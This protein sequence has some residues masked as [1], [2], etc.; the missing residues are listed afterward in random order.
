MEISL[1]AKWVLL[2]VFLILVLIIIA[3]LN[4]KGRGI[5]DLCGKTGGFFGC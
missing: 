5:L 2:V 4:G 3:A 1:L